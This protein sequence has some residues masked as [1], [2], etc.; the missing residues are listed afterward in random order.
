V[1]VRR[2]ILLFSQSLSLFAGSHVAYRELPLL[3]VCWFVYQALDFIGGR[4]FSSSV[5]T[6]FR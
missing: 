3:Q 5:T 4:V 2:V 1:F 6:F